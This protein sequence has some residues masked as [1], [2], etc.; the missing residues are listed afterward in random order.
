[1]GEDAANNP[2]ESEETLMCNHS[3]KSAAVEWIKSNGERDSL[4]KIYECAPGKHDGKLCARYHWNNHNW[5]EAI[6]VLNTM[7][8]TIA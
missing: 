8:T 1:M 2:K 3:S 4:Y 6:R 5:K 7:R